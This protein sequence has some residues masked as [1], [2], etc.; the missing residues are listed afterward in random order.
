MSWSGRR[1]VSTAMATRIGSLLGRT[2]SDS[3]AGIPLFFINSILASELTP[4]LVRRFFYATF[5]TSS[6]TINIYPG[7]KVIGRSL[8][9][10]ERV[11]I[12]RDCLLDSTH[13]SITIGNDVALGHRVALVTSTHELGESSRRAAS[14]LGSAIRICD[15]TWV[16]AGALILPGVTIGEGAII[17]AGSVVTH[18][19]PPNVVAAGVPCRLIRQLS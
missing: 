6:W 11:M 1:K 8:R 19:I 12:N 18:D 10:G 13:A 17:G 2:F 4:R 15:G 14:V 9:L 7:V 5:F 16:G 3:L